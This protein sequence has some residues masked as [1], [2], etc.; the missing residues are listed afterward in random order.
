MDKTVYGEDSKGTAIE[1]L[2][3]YVCASDL[4]NRR[5]YFTES[6]LRT[7][8]SLHAL[9]EDR[10]MPLFPA[11]Y[12]P[13]Y[14]HIFVTPPRSFMLISTLLNKMGGIMYSQKGDG[15]TFSRIASRTKLV[16]RQHHLERYLE[17]MTQAHV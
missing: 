5:Q 11:T 6:C 3:P 14:V 13:S 9:V 7:G 16:G 15:T 4:A 1:F 17:S 8:D 12:H 2:S 10:R